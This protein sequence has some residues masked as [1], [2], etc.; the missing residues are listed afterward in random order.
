MKYVVPTVGE[1]INYER[2]FDGTA[3]SDGS[4]TVPL[5]G[6]QEVVGNML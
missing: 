2:L 6:H 5:H 1:I 3:H 4:V